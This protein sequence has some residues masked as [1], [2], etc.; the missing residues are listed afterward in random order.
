[1]DLEG[2]HEKARTDSRGADSRPRYLTIKQSGSVGQ[3]ERFVFFCHKGQGPNSVSIASKKQQTNGRQEE[4]HKPT[5]K[6]ELPSKASMM[7]SR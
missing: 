5:M 2:C 6:S 3:R 4:C 1:M 7:T